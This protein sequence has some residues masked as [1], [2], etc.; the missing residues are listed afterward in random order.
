MRWR[1]R[2]KDRN[3]RASV[4]IQTIV[5]GGA[6]GLGVAALAVD[7]GLMYG[8]RQELQSA[9]DAAALA[10]ASQ[11][12]ALDDPTN[13]AKTE[14]GRFAN[15]NSIM[16]NEAHMV[17]ADVVF[18]HAVMNGDKFDFQPNQLPYDA[19][20]VSLRRDQTVADGPVS[21]LFGKTLGVSGARMQATAT[22]MLVPRDIALVIDL[23]SSMNDDSELRHHKEFYS[24]TEGLRDGVQIN[25]KEIWTNLPVSKGLAGIKNGSN[26]PAPG[27]PAGGDD[28]PATG[29]GTPQVAGGHPDPGDEPSGGSPNP[30]GPR[31]GWMTGFG[32]AIVLDEYYPVSDSGLSYI[33]KGSPCTDFDVIA[34]LTETGYGSWER[35]ALLSGSYD[36]SSLLYRNRVR[37]L[38][39]LAGWTSGKGEAKFT[40][41]GNGDDVVD[42]DELTQVAAY[43]FASGNWDS[44][45]NYVRSST[46][47]MNK[48]DASLRHRYGIKTFVNYL[49]EKR[50]RNAYTP[51]LVNTPEEPLFSVKNSVQ[52]MINEIVAL[53]TQDHVSLETFGQYGT[54]RVDLTIPDAEQSLASALQEIP[55]AMFGFQAGHD[56]AYTNIGG[57]MDRALEELESDRA[58]TAAAK[59]IIMLTD[60]K[61]NVNEFN[62]I[63]GNNNAE[64]LAWA[65][66]RAATAKERSITVYTI[67]VGGDVNA[68]LITALATSPEHYY[69]ADNA[70]DPNNGGQ[71]QYITQLKAIFQILGGKRP[72]RLIQ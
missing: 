72:V 49:L 60:G 59:V 39:G 18:G 66:D 56:T 4:M 24:G 20:Q 64:A 38:L 46:S 65:E 51:E 19:V 35:T 42:A 8:A 36:G 31:W 53:E 48:T 22:A 27:A 50:S 13:L 26:P 17:D 67:G 9:T 33:P 14:A 28:Q 40:S 21:L 37:V 10:A 68:E 11:L 1:N 25:L 41:G 54:H 23:S 6:V 47:Q 71:P 63:V 30:T 58:R 61:P 29:A 55:D 15:L 32:D 43:P 3:R 7:T 44:Y 34:N 57:G 70:P 5:F 16:G 12:G 45:F 62:N 2:T 52:T 69:F